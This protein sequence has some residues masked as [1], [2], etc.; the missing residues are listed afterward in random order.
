VA[1]FLVCEVANHP[2]QA[3]HWTE[4]TARVVAT[5]AGQGSS[6]LGASESQLFDEG[7]RHG[8]RSLGS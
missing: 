1:L 7:M 4:A 8:N 2:T 6:E 3:V 5:S